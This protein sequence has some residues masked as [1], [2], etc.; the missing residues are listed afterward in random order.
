MNRKSNIDKSFWYEFK[1]YAL[2]GRGDKMILKNK[3]IV[4]LAPFVIIFGFIYFFGK[5]KPP[6][7]TLEESI[8]KESCDC[9]NAVKNQP[10]LNPYIINEE[11]DS[12]FTKKFAEC[13]ALFSTVKNSSYNKGYYGDDM[14]EFLDIIV[15]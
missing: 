8:E 4:I 3:I 11:T 1:T 10:K 12:P 14:T 13:F 2:K 9:L 15:T 6:T 7:L 5:E